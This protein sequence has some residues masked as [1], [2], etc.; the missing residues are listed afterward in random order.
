[1]VSQR[2][3]SLE[4]MSRV[5]ADVLIAGGSERIEKVRGE[6]TLPAHQLMNKDAIAKQTWRANHGVERKRMGPIPR[7][8]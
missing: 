5:M 2:S 3:G 4:M 1:M 8:K 6:T 7:N